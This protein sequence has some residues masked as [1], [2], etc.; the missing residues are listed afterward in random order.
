MFAYKSLAIMSYQET[1]NSYLSEMEIEI[2]LFFKERQMEKK[3]NEIKKLKIN[4]NLQ[5][6]YRE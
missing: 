5:I 4:Q 6:K 3:N 2:V 1:C